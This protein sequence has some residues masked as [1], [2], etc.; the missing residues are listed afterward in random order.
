MFLTF[1]ANKRRD[2]ASLLQR[3][4]PIEAHVP[5][6]PSYAIAVDVYVHQV[7]EK[8]EAQGTETW[9]VDGR[10]ERH[11]ARGHVLTLRH[12]HHVLGS[13][14]ISKVTGLTRHWVTFRLAGTRE[15]AQI[16]V[17]IPWAGLSG[18]YCYTHTTTYHTLSQTPEP[19]AVFRGTPPFADPEENP[20]EFELSPGKLLRL[21]AKF[22]SNRE[23]E[24]TSEMLGNDSICNT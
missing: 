11:L 6:P 7:P 9:V 16:R 23:V 14:R 2:D 17:P 13:G 8:D 3:N 22:V 18:L 1:S 24:S 21:R 15:G 19:H 4:A 5:K 12:E 20:Y 10:P